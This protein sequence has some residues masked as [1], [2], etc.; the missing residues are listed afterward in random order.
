VTRRLSLLEAMILIAALAMGL[1]RSLSEAKAIF[2]WDSAIVGSRFTTIR[3]LSRDFCRQAM[4]PWLATSTLGV[5][6]VALRR[7][8]LDVRGLFRSPRVAGCVAATLGMAM[9]KSAGAWN[10]GFRRFGG[11]W[12]WLVA[13][14]PWDAGGAVLGAWLVLAI[15]GRRRAGGDGLDW[16]G[17]ALGIC[18]VVTYLL[19]YDSL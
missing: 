10:G 1:P 11:F 6:V 19:T 8:R 3:I 12:Y 4:V 5:T 9:G 17:R 18:W 7:Y 2:D 13:D 14:L 16:I 15:G